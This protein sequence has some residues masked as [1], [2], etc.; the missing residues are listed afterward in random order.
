MRLRT[1]LVGSL[2]LPL[3]LL[4]ALHAAEIKGKV[5]SVVGGEALGQIEVSVLELK[6]A[7]IT[8][9]DGTFTLSHI[10]PGNYVLR[11]DAVGYRLLTV[12]FALLTADDSK[13]FSFVMVP[14]NFRRTD[15]VNVT[16]DIFQ[17]GDSPAVIEENLSGSEIRQASTVL[18]DDPFRAVQSLP[19]VSAAGNN[20]LLADFTVLGAPFSQIG[21]YLDGVL[22]PSPFHNAPNVF[23]GASLSLLTSETIDDV[24]LL[25]V[26]YPEKYGDQIGAALDIHTRDGSRTGPLFRAAVGLG[27][28]DLLGEGRLGPGKH[29]SWLASARKSYL[30]YLV[31]NLIRSDFANI[32]FYDGSLKLAYDLTPS[33][34]VTFYG[35]GGNTHVDDPT[36]TL[37]TD[38]RTASTQFTFLRSGWRWSINPHLLLDSRI[39]YLDEPSTQNNL[40]GQLLARSS[41]NEWVAGSSVVW[42]WRK[43]ATLEAGGTLRRL[44]DHFT[45]SAVS[46][47]LVTQSQVALR[48]SGY[49]QQN[50]SLFGDRVHVMGSVRIDARQA[51]D[52]HPVSAQVS[53]AWRVARATD[54]QVGVGRYAQLFFPDSKFTSTPCTLTEQAYQRSNHYSVGVQQRLGENTQVRVQFFDRQSSD[55]AIVSTQLPCVPANFETTRHYSR[56]AELVLQRRSANRL[57]GWLGYTFVQARDRYAISHAPQPEFWTPYFDSFEDQPNSVN[58]FATY[59]LKPTINLSAK[60][61]YGTGFPTVSGVELLPGGG[62]QPSPDQRL[63]AYLRA[64]FRADKCWGFRRW[65][66]T[67]YGEVLNLTNH[68]NRIFTFFEIQPNG[69]TIVHTQRALPITPTAGLAFEF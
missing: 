68:D 31:R 39:A 62:F 34:T 15:V 51:L 40:D 27:D 47:S 52:A 45:N 66:M 56:G 41:Y 32:S 50:V 1:R 25:P 43:N 11:L 28:S 33:H 12:P 64:D 9:A 69:Q 5:T 21:I 17:A 18:A 36:A 13:E 19:G 57:S 54:L 30:G 4:S 20:E 49:A 55:F 67:L 46:G 14:D 65:K 58:A 8:T 35:L 16:A 42:G 2:L 48:G 7:T 53:A 10:P 60:F 61:L 22:I 38:V 63:P 29:G 24:K 6:V 59:R 37:S 3:G 44:A 23:N 26:A